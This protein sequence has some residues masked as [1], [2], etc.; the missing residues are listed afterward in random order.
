M[1]AQELCSL[2]AE[3]KWTECQII[4][5]SR[6]L[7]KG[8]ATW[9]VKSVHTHPVTSMRLSHAESHQVYA[10]TIEQNKPRS[11]P[12]VEKAPAWMTWAQRVQQPMA[13]PPAELWKQCSGEASSS[14]AMAKSSRSRANYS[15]TPPPSY[16]MDQDEEE[17]PADDES[18]DD[19][20]PPWTFEV[21]QL[22]PAGGS[23]PSE[24]PAGKK[25]KREPTRMEKLECQ[26]GDLNAKLER[27]MAGLSIIHQKVESQS[28]GQG[29]QVPSANP[30]PP[31][32]DEVM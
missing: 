15:K 11:D 31:R 27:M 26:L 19:Q 10:I 21:E 14:T 28:L 9:L 25:A 23:R 13:P 16:R 22:A 8:T 29:G 24:E 18:M 32:V 2:L 5:N 30:V 7:F 3:M 1:P 4:E 20:P 17:G 12:K 6:R